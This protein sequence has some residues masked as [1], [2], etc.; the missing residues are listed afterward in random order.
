MSTH[1]KRW[2]LSYAVAAVIFAVVDVV[3]IG[4]VANSQ[5]ERFGQDGQVAQPD[6]LQ[7]PVVLRLRL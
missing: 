2:L 6:S 5:Y 4:T 1:V 7:A 3:W